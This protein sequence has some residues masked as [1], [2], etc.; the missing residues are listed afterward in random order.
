[1]VLADVDNLAQSLQISVQHG[2]RGGGAHGERGDGRR[3]GSAMEDGGRH[4]ASRGNG[5][6]GGIGGA[7]GVDGGWRHA[8]L[9]LRVAGRY[10]G[11]GGLN[12][13]WGCRSERDA[14]HAGGGEGG[15]VGVVSVLYNISVGFGGRVEDGGGH[16]A[17]QHRARFIVF[18][19]VNFCGGEEEIEWR[20]L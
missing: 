16:V 3:R 20:R 8:V 4:A 6:E 12:R 11:L 9:M 15:A 10:R 17:V 1:V 18:V 2:R 14:G 5:G 19:F 13:G 7:D